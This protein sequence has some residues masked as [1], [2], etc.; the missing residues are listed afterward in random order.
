MSEN[1]EEIIVK[2]YVKFQKGNVEDYNNI[3]EKDPN[4]LY[5]VVDKDGW[6]Q[7]YLGDLFMAGD[8]T[9][10]DIEKLKKELTDTDKDLAQ[11]IQNILTTIDNLDATY[12]AAAGEYISTIIQ[13]NG[14]IQVGYTTLPTYTLTTGEENGTLKLNDSEV[15]VKGFEEVENK[16]SQLTE[17]NNKIV[18]SINDINEIID[19][20]DTNYEEEEGYYI[21]NINQTNG[22]INIE[23]KPLPIDTLKTGDENGSVKFNN[24]NIFV[25]GYVELNNYIQKLENLTL[26]TSF[27]VDMKTDSG[28]LFDTLYNHS[29]GVTSNGGN[30]IMPTDSWIN[31]N[32]Y[33]VKEAGIYSVKLGQKTNTN[34]SLRLETNENY[35]NEINLPQNDNKYY[36]YLKQGNNSVVIIN[37]GTDSCELSEIVFENT[38][39]HLPIFVINLLNNYDTSL[40]PEAWEEKIDPPE[41]NRDYRDLDDYNSGTIIDTTNKMNNYAN[42]N[43]TDS[44]QIASS[45]VTMVTGGK[46]IE[47]KIEAPYSGVYAL[48]TYITW[49]T[50]GRT[51]SITVEDGNGY[52]DIINYTQT[53]YS[54]SFDQDILI[55]LKEGENTIRFINNG[56]GNYSL[57][58]FKIIGLNAKGEKHNA[59]F[60]PLLK[61]V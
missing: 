50:S 45:Y 24:E 38:D 37:K 15:K 27:S 29:I 1:N 22:K 32:V 18:D 58:S 53:G 9:D 19:G 33:N 12:T 43:I 44:S 46:W 60:V 61:T 36:I 3:P 26:S 54:Y 56:N 2:P 7:L 25:K 30:I 51:A 13:E 11:S 17:N 23:H 49:M 14:K 57:G 48:S 41:W 6:G 52:G 4:T 42:T 10:A 21:S 31:F 16:L 59:A 55:Y 39:S 47:Y 35:Y 28:N 5:F 20:L 8:V 40:K 34:N